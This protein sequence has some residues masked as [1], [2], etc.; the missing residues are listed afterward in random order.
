[1]TAIFLFIKYPI[2]NNNFIPI[3]HRFSSVN[4]DAVDAS[5]YANEDDLAFAIIKKQ[6]EVKAGDPVRF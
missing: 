2:R 4:T 1:M 5:Q 6:E 3:F